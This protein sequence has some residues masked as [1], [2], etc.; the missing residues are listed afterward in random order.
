MNE[1]KLSNI[2]DGR[3]Q[4][5]TDEVIDAHI[6]LDIFISHSSRDVEVATALIELLRGALSIPAE[7][8][9]C[10]SVDGYRLPVGAPTEE[11]LRRE[12]RDSKVFIGLITP[13]SVQ[14]SYVMFELGARWGADLYLA[15]LLAS[16]V[17]T[18]TLEGPLK[19][20]NVLTCDNKAQVYQLVSNI[21]AELKKTPDSP[22]AYQRYVD[23][24]VRLST[25]KGKKAR[26]KAVESPTKRPTRR[27]SKNLSKPVSERNHDPEFSYE[28]EVQNRFDYKKRR[29]D[30]LNSTEGV[31]SA[32]REVEKLFIELKE[33][34]K[35][36]NEITKDIPI[37]VKRSDNNHCVLSSTG[38]NLN[39]SWDCKH[40]VTLRDSQLSVRIFDNRID[41]TN[42]DQNRMYF[43]EYNID[44]NKDF[45][46][47]W[48]RRGG[49]DSQLIPTIELSAHFLRQLLRTVENKVFEDS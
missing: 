20:I 36:R 29:H 31:I 43:A 1:G 8:I 19:G 49:S 46:I 2:S 32:Q 18:S 15:P 24:I 5:S 22:A 37:E 27:P 42:S 45:E 7:R 34:A 35:K 33:G 38:F 17:N 28:K 26:N 3:P 6:A 12:V 39:V 25:S 11:Q 44:V 47:G 23:A 9:R 41:E 4:A 14:S 13:A 40:E 48:R 10:T 30:W 16:G 21:A